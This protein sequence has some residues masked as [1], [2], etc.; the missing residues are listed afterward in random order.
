MIL[1]EELARVYRQKVTQAI[2]GD[3]WNPGKPLENMGGS[4]LPIVQGLGIKDIGDYQF[5]AGFISGLKYA[6][7]L[8]SET[9]KALSEAPGP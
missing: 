6:L 8:F 3:D 4:L 5:R 1:D 9:T 7:D 2:F